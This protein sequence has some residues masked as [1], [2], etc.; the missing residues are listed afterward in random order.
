[1]SLCV[2]TIEQTEAWDKVV[3]TFSS[4]DVYH[5]SGYVKAFQI[6]G[7][8]EP[9]LF[10]YE[11][12]ELR[13]INVVMKRD[14]AEAPNF[15]GKL[16]EGVYFDFISPYGYGGWLIEGNGDTENLFSAYESWC[17][18]HGVVSEF[19]RYSPV[20]NN[21]R[22]AKTF[23]DVTMLGETI[24]MDLTSAD[25]IWTNLTSKNRNMVR[26]AMKAGVKIYHGQFPEIYETFREMY[27]ATMDSNEA[28][29]YYYFSD[30]F[31]HSILNDLPNE[32]Q[33]FWAQLDGK[34]IAA[35]IMLT[36]N[37]HM[38]YHLAGSLREYQHL[39]PSN[40]LLYQAALWGVANGC[41]SFHLG[42]GVG[43]QKDSLYKFKSAFNRNDRLEYGIGKKVYL[44]DTYQ[45]LVEMNTNCVNK[46]FFPEYRV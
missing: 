3:K 39:A 12:R 40:L 32:A 4:Y 19:M 34:I 2:Y 9:M 46:N 20:Q 13:G 16:E 35:A 21:A 25:V 28:S 1:M 45:K 41:K 27:N 37:G 8:G 6:H 26:K 22:Y 11:D 24:A 18:D 33:V 14:V 7:D 44:A 5:L 36:A 31:Y 43:C 42:G 15:R 17:R 10:Y 23:Y 30:A 38:N 29:A